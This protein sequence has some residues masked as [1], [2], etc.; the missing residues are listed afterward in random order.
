[1][2]AVM[3]IT[4]G[5]A[6]PNRTPTCE[7]YG[8][9]TEAYQFFNTRLFGGELPPC[10]ITL[11]RHRSAYGY[12]CPQVFENVA[13][14]RADEIA[15]N[16]DHL[17]ARPDRVSLSTLVHEMV[18]LWQQHFGKPSRGGYH[19]KE[20]A[21]KMHAVGL[22]P[23]T[24]GLQG[25]NE[26]GPRVSHFIKDGGPYDR[27]CAELLKGGLAITWKASP[28]PKGVS[29]SGSRTK[30]TCSSCSA[31]VWGK[32]GLSIECRSCAE[33]MEAA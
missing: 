4:D 32:D 2:E 9:L 10:L 3:H 19:N 21:A 17:K 13:G 30:Y 5:M 6:R 28:R 14:K 29:K 16:P 33:T 25:G 11:H 1:M 27:A 31:S 24:T 22:H 18:H 12:F 23:S 20:W 7:S 15:L 26:V 8:E